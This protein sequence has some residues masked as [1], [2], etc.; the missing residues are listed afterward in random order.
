M[1][2]HQ[3]P[4]QIQQRLYRKRMSTDVAIAHDAWCEH[5]HAW[6]SFFDE[7]LKN[8]RLHLGE[9]QKDAW[10]LSVLLCDDTHIQSLNAQFRHKDKPTNV[11]SFP[12]GEDICPEHEHE[13]YL[14]DLAFSFERIDEESKKNEKIFLNHMT[15]LTIHGILHLLG[16]DHETDADAYVM[17]TLEIDILDKMNIK[18]PYIYDDTRNG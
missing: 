15:H 17:E 9:D 10:S 1:F 5:H 12:S 2:F 18:N 11:L 7:I 3:F 6:E 4:M 13:R 16:Y 14:G 8:I